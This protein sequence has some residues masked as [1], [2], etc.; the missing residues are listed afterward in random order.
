MIISN[1]VIKKTSFCFVLFW[2]VRGWIQ[3]L[4]LARQELYHLNHDPRPFCFGYLFF[5]YCC[6]GWGCIMAL[7]K[8]LT[9]YQIYYTSCPAGLTHNA[10]IYPSCISV[11][12]G[13][14]PSGPSFYWLRQGLMN[15]LPRLNLRSN[16][17]G[18]CLLSSK[19]Y[20]CETP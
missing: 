13:E 1:T 9:M 20:T 11:V 5:L 8:V 12:T 6:A 16:P 17:P 19:D 2:G 7:T 15:T 3:G 14:C 18:L 4:A 10:F